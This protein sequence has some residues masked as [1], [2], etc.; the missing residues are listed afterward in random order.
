MAFAKGTN[1]V[2]RCQRSGDKVPY[3]KLVRDGYR[4]NLLVSPAWRDT[5][6]PQE[7]PVRMTE[8][9]ALK[10]P[11]PD[12]DADVAAFVPGTLVAALFPG[13]GYFGGGT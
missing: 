3:Y 1:A 5:A 4:K 10:S 6:H 7:K 13:G 12:T 2:G 9:V 11:S 8:G